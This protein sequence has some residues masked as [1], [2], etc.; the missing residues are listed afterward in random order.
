M[1]SSYAVEEARRNLEASRQLNAFDKQLRS[2][3]IIVFAEA[4]HSLPSSIKLPEK[5]RPILLAAIA[6]EASHLIT[7]DVTH[8]GRY[9]GKKVSG[10][11]ILPPSDYAEA[12]GI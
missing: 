12:K 7:G 9:F 1:T 4:L 5:D 8:F 2:V 10:V 3:E 6:A 11:M